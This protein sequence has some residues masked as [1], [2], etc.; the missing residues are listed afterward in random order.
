[1]KKLF[2]S[3]LF[4]NGI[5]M[6]IN[7]VTGILSARGLGPQGRGELA[8]IYQ[9]NGLLVGIFALGL[10]GAVV[11]LG[12]TYEKQRES[13]LGAYLVTGVT[14]G[15]IGL[16]IGQLLLPR[17]L[18]QSPDEVIW[19]AQLAMFGLPLGVLSDGMSGTLQSINQF[20]KVMLLRLL[21]PLGALFIIASLTLAGK[22]TV[23]SFV[24]LNFIWSILVATLSLIWVIRLIKPKLTLVWHRI[25][26]LLGKGVQIYGTALVNV[27]GGSLD[28]LVISLLLS[29]Y[30]LG[31]YTVALSIGT[32]IPSVIIGSLNVYLWPKL[33][34]MPQHDRQR[35]VEYTHSILFYVTLVFSLIA[36][37]VM[38]FL[39]P[40]VYGTEFAPAIMIGVIFLLI[41]PLRVGQNIIACYLSTEGKFNQV[42]IAEVCG[43]VLGIVTLPFLLPMLGGVGAAV[44]VVVSTLVKWSYLV[45]RASK[46]GLHVAQLFRFR[47]SAFIQLMESMMK[48]AAPLQKRMRRQDKAS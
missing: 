24:I 8:L 42:T 45:W 29:A 28:Q 26:Q 44:A 22:Y 34:D 23:S 32:I 39:L 47:T 18:T 46:L 37:I 12:K 5:V 2:F 7:L 36:L 31:L 48:L 1:M 14:L 43:L 10:P 16:A 17:L 9:W 3:G 6:V 21:V 13:L 27:F 40:V 11:Y 20:N 30:F 4:L 15:L 25:K 41:A 38:P 33:M 35:K 19:L